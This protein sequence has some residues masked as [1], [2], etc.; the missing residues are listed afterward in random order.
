MVKSAGDSS[1]LNVA[2]ILELCITYLDS[3]LLSQ[4]VPKQKHY[5]PFET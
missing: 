3:V 4:S 2:F 5:S 1:G